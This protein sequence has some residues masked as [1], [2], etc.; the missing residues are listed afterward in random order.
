MNDP[1]WILRSFAELSEIAAVEE[2]VTDND[3]EGTLVPIVFVAVT[4][5]LYVVALTREFMT[6][7]DMLPVAIMPLQF[8][9]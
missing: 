6:I 8:A 5:Q 7:G 4:L 9:V 2:G 1:G 3:V